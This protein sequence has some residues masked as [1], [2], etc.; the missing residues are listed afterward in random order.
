MTNTAVPQSTVSTF[1]LGWALSATFVVL[2]A[3]C[4]LAIFV[5]PNTSFSHA[6]LDL[7]TKAPITSVRAW[8][9]GVLW[10]VVLGWIAALAFALTYNWLARR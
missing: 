3:V 8:A 6:W 2:F 10:S 4:G 5:F 1:A 9:E 7:F